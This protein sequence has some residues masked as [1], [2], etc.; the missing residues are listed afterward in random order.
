MVSLVGCVVL[1]I[2]YQLCFSV[3]SMQR[4]LTAIWLTL[5]WAIS[6]QSPVL[7]SINESLTGL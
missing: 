4:V 2:S 1:R 6:C 5:S 3:S 7:S